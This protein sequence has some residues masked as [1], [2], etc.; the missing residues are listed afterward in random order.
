M[1]GK[2]N[3]IED[4]GIRLAHGLHDLHLE[5]NLAPTREAITRGITTGSESIWKT[6]STIRS[7][8]TKRQTERAEKQRLSSQ[9]GTISPPIDLASPLLAGVDVAKTGAASLAT[10]I[11][12]F[13]S[14]KRTQFFAPATVTPTTSSPPVR[15]RATSPHSFE[16]SLPPLYPTSASDDEDE[17]LYQLERE[18]TSP[19]PPIPSTPSFGSFFR[20]PSISSFTSGTS[21]P[22]GSGIGMG[23]P[24]LLAA[25]TS[26]S[27]TAS[28]AGFFSAF[29]RRVSDTLAVVE[30]NVRQNASEP[31]STGGGPG[32][33]PTK[34]EEEEEDARHQEEALEMAKVRD[35]DK[36]WE[37]RRQRELESELERQEAEEEMREGHPVEV[38]Q[39]EGIHQESEKEEE[40]V[41]PLEVVDLDA[42]P[43]EA[44]VRQ[45]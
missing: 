22:R 36:E 43:V 17:R 16:G 2:T 30:S 21:S 27:G 13:L 23:S 3:P 26:S 45:V 7:D 4:V 8:F 18:R 40:E 15:P 11:G 5:E 38:E 28:P 14:S 31:T 35:L 29:S 12:S 1:E 34:V 33:L 41:I 25:S 24:S 19:S 42:G 20:P 32:S 10:G 39:K 6:Y 9:S 37:E 44:D